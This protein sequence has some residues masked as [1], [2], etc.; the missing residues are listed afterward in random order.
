MSKTIVVPEHLYNK[1][2]ELAAKDHVSVE[3]Y[4]STLLADR[5]ASHEYIAA[6]AKLFNQEDFKR[7]LSEVP[8]VEPDECDRL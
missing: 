1:A 6:H 3:E 8:D 7:I 2:A 4:V 5:V